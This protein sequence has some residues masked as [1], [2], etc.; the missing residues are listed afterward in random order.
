MRDQLKK[1]AVAFVKSNEK[2]KHID[3]NIFFITIHDAVLNASR[4]IAKNQKSIT[5]K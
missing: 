3:E 1:I 5:S 4:E 2:V